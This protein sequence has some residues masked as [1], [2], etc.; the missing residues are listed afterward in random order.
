MYQLTVGPLVAVFGDEVVQAHPEVDVRVDGDPL[1]GLYHAR[2]L[3]LRVHGHQVGPQ[4]A[5]VV[6]AFL[7]RLPVRVVH[8][9]LHLFIEISHSD[10]F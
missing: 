3:L 2:L 9:F 5:T 7:P 1:H 6:H 4:V 8:R 10:F